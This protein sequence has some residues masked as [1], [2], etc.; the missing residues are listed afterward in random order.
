MHGKAGHAR[1]RFPL[2]VLVAWE[3]SQQHEQEDHG[4]YADED[5]NGRKT[6]ADCRRAFP[7]PVDSLGVPRLSGPVVKAVWAA[8]QLVEATPLSIAREPQQPMAVYGK[9]ADRT[10]QADRSPSGRECRH[11]HKGEECPMKPTRVEVS[12]Y[13]EPDQ[14]SSAYGDEPALT[15]AHRRISGLLNPRRGRVAEPPY[16]HAPPFVE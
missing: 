1:V 13:K 16:R 7:S 15:P 4:N 12:A 5:P 6:V 9:P 2:P 14:R 3:P 8:R 10:A 11:Y